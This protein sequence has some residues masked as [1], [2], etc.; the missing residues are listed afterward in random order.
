MKEIKKGER[1]MLKFDLQILKMNYFLIIK[2]IVIT[3]SFA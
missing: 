1:K 3:L 2:D